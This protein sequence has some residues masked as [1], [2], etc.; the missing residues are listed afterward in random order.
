MALVEHLAPHAS[1]L[2]QVIAKAAVLVLSAHNA[3]LVGMY[4]LTHLAPKIVL[5]A[6]T[7]QVEYVRHAQQDNGLLGALLL[8]V[9]LAILAT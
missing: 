3:I 4:N 8:I 7:F 2:V 6:L 5:P 9:L 1:N